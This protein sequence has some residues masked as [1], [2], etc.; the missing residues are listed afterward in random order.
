MKKFAISLVFLGVFFLVY[1]S[2]LSYY[3]ELETVKNKLSFIEDLEKTSPLLFPLGFFCLYIIVTLFS[4]PG[5]AVMMTLIAGAIFGFIKGIILVSFS[6][7]I[8]A[9]LVFLIS[10]YLLRDF[11]KEKF[12]KSI[13]TIDAG[14]EKDGSFYLFTIRLLPIFPFFLVNLLMGLTNFSLKKYYLI[15]QLG[16]LPGTLAYL[17]AGFQL[18]QLESLKGILSF[19]I[20]ISFAVLG[21]L[22]LI[23]KR[24]IEKL[25]MLRV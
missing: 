1:T 4:L 24:L 19:N 9:S 3:T 22:P 12:Q 23:S 20:L 25:K 14:L 11:V 18:S 7:T 13:K 8:G 6:S 16:M 10:R 21:F 2:N 5:G 15:S 17:N